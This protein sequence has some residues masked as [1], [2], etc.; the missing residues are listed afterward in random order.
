[1]H[2]LK[3]NNGKS[4]PAIGLGT[5]QVSILKMKQIII[6]Y[7][8]FLIIL[9]LHLNFYTYKGPPEKCHEVKQAILNAIDIGYRHFDCAHVYQ[10]EKLIGEAL[11]EKIKEGAVKR[12]DLFITSKL[13]N[14]FHNPNLVEM[15][16]KT[17][18]NN[19]MLDYLDLY[20]IHWPHGF[21]VRTYLHTCY[22]FL[23]Y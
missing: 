3:L 4:I 16:L 5:W 17:T 8:P 14:T 1:M 19:L 2:Y 20:L 9:Y 7:H 18:L 22:T 10:N 15:A 11:N 21:Q 6:N 13:W 23:F 12:E